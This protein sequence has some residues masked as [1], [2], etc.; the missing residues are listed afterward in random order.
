MF[1]E[2][3]LAPMAGVCTP[4]LVAKACNA[5][6]I[7]SLGGGMMAPAALKDAIADIRKQVGAH[8]KYNINLFVVDD[9]PEP[10]NH[11]TAWSAPPWFG[12]YCA[13]QGYNVPTDL[14]PPF[15]PRF[16]EQFEVVLQSKPPIA[17]FTFG[18]LPPSQINRCKAAGIEVWGT[19]TSAEEARQWAENGADVV[20]LQ[21]CEAGGHQGSFNVR[22]DPSMTG[23]ENLFAN[24]KEQV[25]IPIIVAGGIMS[26]TT[27]KKFIRQGAKAAQ[28]GTIFLGATDSGIAEPYFQALYSG[29]KTSLT[30]SFTGRWARGIDNKFIE[31][32]ASLPALPYPVQ[33]R[34]TQP[35]RKQ[36]ALAGDLEHMSMWAGTNLDR[37]RKKSVSEIVSELK[38][39]MHAAE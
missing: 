19:A 20:V 27:I 37:C 14:A 15:A 18:I 1:S 26:G 30:R 9:S 38:S 13:E 16:T 11:S 39:E 21:G 4:K 29:R 33:N 25:N 35:L 6:I 31:E 10:P 12:N 5:G 24:C 2:I 7:G 32:T 28:L 36:A 23:L 17:S 8:A 22:G 3:V 34:L